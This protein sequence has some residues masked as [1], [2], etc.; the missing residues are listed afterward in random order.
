MEKI[1]MCGYR[2][3][4]CKAFVSNIINKDEREILSNMWKKYYD[5]DILAEE[6]YCDGCR[7]NNENV[8]RIDSNCPVRKCVID[9]NINNCGECIDF[10]CTVFNERRGLS[11]QEAKEKLGSD[12]CADEYNSNLLAYDNFTRL[13]EYIKKK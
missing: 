8:K 12:F 3:D 9:K 5:L 2:C 7:C 6:I 1:T 11:F 4:L 13:K 10:P